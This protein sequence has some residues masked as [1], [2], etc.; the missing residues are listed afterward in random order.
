M[1]RTRTTFDPFNAI[2][3]PKRRAL[4]EALVGKELTV[5]QIVEL[6]GW[7]QPMVSKHLGVLKQVGLVSERKEG[8]YRVYKVNAAQLKPIQEWVVQF[9]Q[10][11]SNSLDHLED[12]LDEI[13]SKEV[14]MSSDNEHTVEPTIITRE[15]NAPRQLVFDAWTQPEHLKNWMFPQKGFTC[16]YVSADIKP[17]GSSLHKMTAPNGSEMWLLTKYEEVTSPESL[18]FR[19]YISNE[20]GDILSNPQMPN[21]PKELRTTIKLEEMGGKTKLQLIWQP[22]NPTKEEAEAFEASRS[23]HGAGWG[24]G[25]DQLAAYLETL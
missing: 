14:N 24:G 23:Q 21:W 5:N 13:Q 4:I 2:A 9:E 3:E 6:M 12:Y 7:T 1:A 17:G 25:L 18:V 15:F 16:E 22:I 11:W 10:F 19:Q 8:R 20:A